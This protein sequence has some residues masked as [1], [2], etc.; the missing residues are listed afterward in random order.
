MH[1]NIVAA[2]EPSPAYT[3]WAPGTRRSASI[4][5]R[6]DQ[7]PS[8]LKPSR[9]IS[10]FPNTHHPAH[11]TIRHPTP[12]KPI[13]LA[14]H[15]NPHRTTLPP[16]H[17]IENRIVQF[18]KRAALAQAFGT[19]S[20]K[21]PSERLT[22]V[23]IPGQ[24][25]RALGLHGWGVAVMRRERGEVESPKLQMGDWDGERREFGGEDGRE[26]GECGD[27]AGFRSV[28]GG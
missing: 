15:P 2:P 7:T 25:L 11:Q 28:E 3:P 12:D 22:R 23:R 10:S 14:P 9:I 16:N 1:R 26:G 27:N 19:S 13:Q 6:G 5:T 4:F 21:I 24:G 20:D 17:C 8:K 18:P